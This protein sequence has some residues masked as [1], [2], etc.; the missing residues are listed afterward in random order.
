ML[1][2]N[3]L[4]DNSEKITTECLKQEFILDL[5]NYGKISSVNGL[6]SLARMIQ[7]LFLLDP[8]SYPNHPEMGIG[9]KN[10]KFEFLDSQTLNELR[11]AAE[12]QID[13]Y[14][15]NEYVYNIDIQKID[16][17]NDGRHNAIGVLVNLN[18]SI[19]NVNSVIVTFENLGSVGKIKSQIYV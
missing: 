8:G 2:T 12:K 4:S 15:P 10:Y 14:I 9:I 3:L 18:Q 7:T 6:F 13:K 5:D 11:M 19:D 1:S 17:S 16:S